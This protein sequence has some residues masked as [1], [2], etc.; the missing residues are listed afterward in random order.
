M[1]EQRSSKVLS[2]TLPTQEPQGA[3]SL[4]EHEPPDVRS[5]ATRLVRLSAVS[6]IENIEVEFQTFNLGEAPSFR[7][8]S[9]MWGPP[10]PSYQILIRYRAFLVRRNLYEF[11]NMVR[12][13]REDKGRISS[14]SYQRV[15]INI[16]HFFW[17][18]NLYEER[19]P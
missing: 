10:S 13:R 17:E 16:H 3:D 4:F 19:S 1:I 11:F 18:H 15:V 14:V 9:Y 7:A 6:S 8:L 5:K 2:S 12:S